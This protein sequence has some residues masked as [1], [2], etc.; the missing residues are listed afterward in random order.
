MKNFKVGKIIKKGELPQEP[1][2]CPV[3]KS[4]T[5]RLNIINLF[6]I[7]SKEPIKTIQLNW[8]CSICG[9]ICEAL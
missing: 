8:E 9:T 3:C 5:L 7:G 4:K 6:G 2:I 1:K